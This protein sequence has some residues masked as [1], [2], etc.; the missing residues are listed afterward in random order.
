MTRGKTVVAELIEGRTEN[1]G[2]YLHQDPTVEHDDLCLKD[3]QLHH[4][5]YTDLLWSLDNDI[6]PSE[7]DPKSFQ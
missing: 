7:N 4:N 6:I 2:Q 3:H 1:R 5:I